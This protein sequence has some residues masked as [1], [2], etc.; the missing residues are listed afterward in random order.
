[1]WEIYDWFGASLLRLGIASLTEEEIEELAASTGRDGQRYLR[2]ALLAN[3]Y[4]Y[5]G[6]G[7]IAATHYDS[8]VY[9]TERALARHVEKAREGIVKPDHHIHLMTAMIFARAGRFDRAREE[10]A[11]TAQIL[12]IEAC[13]W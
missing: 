10:I 1:S 11:L 2:F 13:H 12:P 5:R 4:S 6:E 8:A 9:Y 7:D 3:I